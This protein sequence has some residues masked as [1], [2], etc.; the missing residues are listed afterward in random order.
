[1][2]NYPASQGNCDI[3][4]GFIAVDSNTGGFEYASYTLSQGGSSW[5]VP[6]ATGIAIPVSGAPPLQIAPTAGGGSEIIVAPGTFLGIDGV[7]NDGGTMSLNWNNECNGTTDLEAYEI[8][9]PPLAFIQN[10]YICAPS[11]QDAIGLPAGGDWIIA[12]AP[13]PV[14]EPATLTLLVLALLGLGI[15]YLRRR[16]A[17]A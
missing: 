6:D 15:F 9:P 5:T 2:A 3:S 12:T 4:P 10:I 17:K 1:M 11:L 16:R 14:P 7:D 13:A 8:A